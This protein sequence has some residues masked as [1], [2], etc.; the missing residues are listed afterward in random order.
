MRRIFFTICSF[1][2]AL[3]FFLNCNTWA[4]PEAVSDSGNIEIYVDG[5]KYKSVESYRRQRVTDRLKKIKPSLKDDEIKQW[6]ANALKVF[7]LDQLAKMSDEEIGKLI[8]SSNFKESKGEDA[9]KEHSEM[10]LMLKDF[11]K[12]NK[13]AANIDIN[14]EKVKTIVITPKNEH[15][16]GASS[17]GGGL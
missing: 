3:L 1:G 15:N 4:Q 10:E 16:P 11:K 12:K 6:M 7:S 13:D 8:I 9:E 17:S 14:M 2:L 5:T